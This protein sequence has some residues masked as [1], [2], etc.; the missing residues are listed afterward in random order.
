MAS[1]EFEPEQM[2]MMFKTDSDTDK[3]VFTYKYW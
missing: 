3:R 2:D 1:C